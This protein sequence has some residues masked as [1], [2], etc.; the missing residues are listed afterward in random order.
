MEVWHYCHCI[1]CSYGEGSAQCI[2]TFNSRYISA[3]AHNDATKD[4]QPSGLKYKIVLG[5]Q[6]H[7][8]AI[9]VREKTSA[10]SPGL[11]FPEKKFKTHKN[12]EPLSLV[13]SCSSL[14]LLS[15]SITWRSNSATPFSTSSTLD[16]SA[17]TS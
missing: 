3:Y 16:C 6:Y 5:Y 4:E 2:I 17:V 10:H 12:Q 1:W 8:I 11:V 14:A 7:L 9:S 15:I 13:S